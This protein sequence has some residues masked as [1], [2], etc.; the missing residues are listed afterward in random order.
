MECVRAG[1]A[2]AFFVD[3]PGGTGKIFLYNALYAEV[4]LMGEVVF[5][6]S[7]SAIAA[8]NIP[9][10]RT[11]HSR[12]KIPLDSDVSLCC[13]VPK[14]S[15]LAAL[16]RAYRL[17]IWDE[18]SMARRQNIESLDLLLRDLC[19]PNLLFGGK[20]VVFGGDFCETLPVVPEKSR[21]EIV[22]ASLV[23]S[24]LWLKLIKFGLTE[25]LRARSDPEFAGF[26]LALGN[27]S[28]LNKEFE[29][30]QLPSGIVRSPED[31]SPNPITDLISV[32]FPEFCLELFD[33]D[34]FTTR[35]IIT[36][37]NEVMDTINDAL[38]DK[39]PG[40]PVSCKSYDAMLDDNCNIYPSE[41]INKLNP[42]GMS[43]HNLILKERCPV[44]LLSNLQPSFGLCNGTRLICK[45]FYPNS[46]ECVIT[47]GHH[48][49][50]HAFI[51]RIKLHPA[52]SANYPFQFQRTQF[53]LKLSFEMTFS[54]C[55]G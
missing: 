14:Q 21:V 53:P 51:P 33:S 11:A 32:A 10:G 50:E 24:V 9:S 55:Q 28:L 37:L 48:K 45:R 3:G 25:N 20:V 41:F 39:F 29:Y 42:G 6:T 19:D 38:I 1:K 44:I 16:I 35:A 27:G 47:T 40:Y 7:S 12:F 43:P 52:T 23:S 2:G 15:S 8:S 46:V 31:V 54:K 30:I 4:Q 13:D 49:G 22:E 26:L 34:I 18:A 5:P 17:I 36:P